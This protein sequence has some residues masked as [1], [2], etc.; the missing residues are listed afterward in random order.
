MDDSQAFVETLVARVPALRPVLDEHVR[1][2]D[3]VLPHVFMGDVTRFVVEQ[4]TAD[5]DLSSVNSIL[6][7]LENGLGIASEPITDVILASFVENLAG[8]GRALRVLLPLM[9]EELR[10]QTLLISG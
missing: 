3:C 9:G 5:G 10:K 2:H 1:D 6:D 4:A 8:E 7:I